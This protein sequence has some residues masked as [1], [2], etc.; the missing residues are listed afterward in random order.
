MNNM[1]LDTQLTLGKETTALRV[2]AIKNQSG[3]VELM[4]D[5]LYVNFD[6]GNYHN[7]MGFYDN[8]YHKNKYQHI[9]LTADIFHGDATDGRSELIINTRYLESIKLE[10]LEIYTHSLKSLNRKIERLN[11]NEGFTNTIGE[12]VARLAKV[13]KAKA[14]YFQPGNNLQYERNDSIQKIR[15][16]V[17]DLINQLLS[18]TQQAA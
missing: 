4:V 11:D 10:D 9:T 12:D 3:F 13:V 1:N 5:L 16:Y 8:Q 17:D 6:K 15:S 14:F 18:P 2:S 7:S